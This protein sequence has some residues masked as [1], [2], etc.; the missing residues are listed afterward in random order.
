VC[1]LLLEL[2]HPNTPK[3]QTEGVICA[4]RAYLEDYLFVFFSDVLLIDRCGTQ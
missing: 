3:F 4:R 1:I 2:P